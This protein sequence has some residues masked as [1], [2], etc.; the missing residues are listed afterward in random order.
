MI[1]GDTCRHLNQYTNKCLKYDKPLEFIRGDNVRY[2]GFV[3][4]EE[5]LERYINSKNKG[6]KKKVK[7]ER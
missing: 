3:R 7:D 2:S 1:C 5:C 4:C 6:F